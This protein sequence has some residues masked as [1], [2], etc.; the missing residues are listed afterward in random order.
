MRDINVVCITGRV[1]RDAELRTTA[2]GLSVCNFGVCVN[3]SRKNSD[4]KYEDEPNFI[5]CTMLGKRADAL[6]EYLKKGLK[7]TV[8]GS[9][10]QRT[11]EKDGQKRSKVEVFAEDVQL[12][13][14]EKQAQQ[15][16]MQDD[17]EIYGSEIPF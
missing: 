16:E 2:Q 1:T 11:W 8:K 6:G 10:R 4:G 13:P 14:R 17:Y 9:L 5:D 12:P 7:V 3:G 15:Q